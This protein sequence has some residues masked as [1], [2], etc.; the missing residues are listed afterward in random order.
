METQKTYIFVNIDLEERKKQTDYLVKQM[1]DIYNIDK[2]V[3]SMVILHELNQEHYKA[4]G[5]KDKEELSYYIYKAYDE[6][7]K[8]LGKNNALKIELERLVTY[9]FNSKNKINL[10]NP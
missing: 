9:N 4:T 8:T 2:V 7:V 3:N 6:S 10:L 1:L 5:I